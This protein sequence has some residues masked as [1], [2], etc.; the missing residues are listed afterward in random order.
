MEAKK[1]VEQSCPLRTTGGSQAGQDSESMGRLLHQFAET[2]LVVDS[3]LGMEVSHRTWR[4][5]IG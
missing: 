5:G 1:P 4:S 2:C 3:S